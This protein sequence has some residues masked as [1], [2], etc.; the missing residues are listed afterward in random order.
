MG[1]EAQNMKNAIVMA[2]GKGTRMHSD[3]PKVLHRIL[4]EP[5]AGLIVNN[6]KKAGAERVVSIVGYG[7][8]L[9][10]A[11]LAG[12]CEFAVQEPQ[13]GT[14]H[15][16]MQARQL[17]TEKGLT[18][19][20]NGDGPCV[21]PE[22]YARL[23][24]ALEHAEMA[25][26]T[27][28]PEYDNRFGRVIRGTDGSVEKIV[29]YKDCTDEERAVK[30]TNMGFY[31][32][33]NEL[34]FE[35]L[36]ELTNNNAQHEYYITDLVEIFIRHGY[37]VAAVQVEDCMEVQGVNDNIELARA[38][39]YLQQ[40]I[41]TGLMASGVTMVDPNTAYIG[42]YVTVGHDVIIHPNVY[43]YGKTEIQ[44]GAVILPGSYLRDALVG[45]GETIGPNVYSV[46]AED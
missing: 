19:V 15:A 13:L 22:T 14:G 3:Q 4:D 9:V 11:A 44:D 45:Q 5:M 41:N 46:P 43:L 25:I 37:K 30:E 7:H 34:L 12:T 31:A 27:A 16:V 29:E 8:E 10:E 21:R 32:F 2:A 40:R 42:P 17:E 35:G 33:R 36:K 18:G 1:R 23:Y 26:M 6:L 20:V 28:V 39:A 24:D 38:S